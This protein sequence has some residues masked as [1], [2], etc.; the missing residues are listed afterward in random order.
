MKRIFQFRNPAPVHF[1]FVILMVAVLFNSC[2]PTDDTPDDK[3]GPQLKWNS[4]LSIDEDFTTSSILTGG[5][6]TY[7]F[8]DIGTPDDICSENHPICYW[9][10][11]PVNYDEDTALLLIQGKVYWNGLQGELVTLDWK[12]MQYNAVKEIGLKMAYPDKPAW[13]GMN[14]QVTFY[15]RGSDELNKAFLNSRIEKMS[16]EVHYDQH[17]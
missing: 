10:L 6:V 14:M 11:E 5:R 12:G 2:K 7:F 3:C 4:T 17:K 1:N 15:D 9:I 13:I 16:V 8:E